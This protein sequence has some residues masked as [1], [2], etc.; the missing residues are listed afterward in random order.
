LGRKG[1]STMPK[2]H[3]PYSPE[4]R[5]RIVE[6][7]RKGRTPEELARQFE[8]SAQAIRNWV[9]QAALDVGERPDG[10][11]TEE[12]DELRRLRREVRQL[13]E[14]RAILSKAAAWFAR[15]TTTIPSKDSR[16]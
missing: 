1:R 13:R 5:Q 11:T 10:L 12:R 14:E 6:L 8:P 4:F 15:E 9:K 7:V 3:P 16:S 2:S